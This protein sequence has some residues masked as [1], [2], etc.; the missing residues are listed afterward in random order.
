MNLSSPPW[1]RECV[2][3]VL[4]TG[5]MHLLCKLLIPSRRTVSPDIFI[6]EHTRRL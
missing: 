4:Y 1:R 5:L 2:D 6:H 3:C